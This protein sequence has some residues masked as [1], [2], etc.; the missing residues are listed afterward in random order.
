[1]KETRDTQV[2]V[3]KII[4]MRYG[5]KNIYLRSNHLLFFLDFAFALCIWNRVR[6]L[7]V[8]QL[9]KVLLLNSF[10]KRMR[11]SIRKKNQHVHVQLKANINA[12]SFSFWIRLTREEGRNCSFILWYK[13]Y[14]QETNACMQFW[15]ANKIAEKFSNE[16]EPILW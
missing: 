6:M 12:F 4:N 2:V 13:L 5:S 9:Q 15:S 11:S 1:M 10:E 8:R 14:G 3:K 16:I 7:K